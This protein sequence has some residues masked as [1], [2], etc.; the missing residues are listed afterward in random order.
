[1]ITSTALVLL[2]IPGVGYVRFPSLHDTRPLTQDLKAF[3]TLDWR[4]ENPH[5]RCYG[6]PSWRLRSSPFSGFSG[7]IRWLSR[8]RPESTLELWTT[9]H[10]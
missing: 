10:L 9:S 5:Y 3:F 6:F 8:T 7:D 4:D 1:M 2:M